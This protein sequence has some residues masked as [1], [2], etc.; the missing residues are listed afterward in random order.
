MTASP[1]SN[2]KAQTKDIHQSQNSAFDES[3]HFQH[4]NNASRHSSNHSSPMTSPQPTHFASNLN[5]HLQILGNHPASPVFLD[6]QT[7][8][9]MQSRS[10]MLFSEYEAEYPTDLNASPLSD[11]QASGDFLYSHH[12][13][14]RAPKSEFSNDQ[15]AAMAPS[16]MLAMSRSFSE[17]QISMCDDASPT[18]L[19]SQ[20][21]LN[22]A[23]GAREDMCESPLVYGSQNVYEDEYYLSH[24]NHHHGHH[25]SHHHSHPHHHSHSYSS[26]SLSTLSDDSS[27]MSP[28]SP[29]SNNMSLSN[30]STSIASAYPLSRTLSEPLIP[31]FQSESMMPSSDALNPDGVKPAPKRSRGRRVSSHP[32]NSGCK[33]FTCRYEDCGKIFKRSEHLKRHVRSIHTMDKPF[34]CPIQNCPKRFSR[35][36]NLNQH[37][38]IHRHSPRG[39]KDTNGL[40]NLHH[41]EHDPIHSKAFASFTPFLQS[42]S[43]DMISLN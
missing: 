36:D 40:G 3:Y 7:D 16:Y 6:M 43:T 18:F 21:G 10:N 25:H 8:S 17:S 26:S 32:D 14:H 9:F 19:S 31:L 22:Q 34:E 11:T 27:S 35:S 38:R 41:H 33:V 42:Y 1:I 20:A 24:H 15:F 13:T 37:I 30:S 28:R 12:S 5:H 39:K 29:F 2:S 23:T 4:V